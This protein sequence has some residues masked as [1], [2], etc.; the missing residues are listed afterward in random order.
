MVGFFVIGIK[1]ND[2]FCRVDP[3]HRVLLDSAEFRRLVTRR[4]RLSLTL[5]ALLFILYYGYI[6]LIAADRA[7]LSRRIGAVT[8]VGIPLGAAVIVGAWALTAWYVRWA[9]RHY[10]AE[11]ARLR[12]RVR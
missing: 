2:T 7:F 8:T 12:E 5:T 10:D 11:V 9:N 4:W 6:L 1:A 3:K